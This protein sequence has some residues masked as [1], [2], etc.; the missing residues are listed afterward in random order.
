M[1]VLS[2]SRF[3]SEKH[4]IFK[5]YFPVAKLKLLSVANLSSVN[6]TLKPAL[7]NSFLVLLVIQ[8]VIKISVL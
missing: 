7:L 4:P 8:N 1:A 6:Q 2:L 3:W 5:I